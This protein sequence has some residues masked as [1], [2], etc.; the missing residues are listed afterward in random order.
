MSEY[1][2]PAAFS[3]GN[4]NCT[5]IPL[6]PFYREFFSPGGRGCLK[7]KVAFSPNSWGSLV[8]APCNELSLNRRVPPVPPCLAAGESLESGHGRRRHRDLVGQIDH[9]AGP[10]LSVRWRRLERLPWCLHFCPSV[11]RGVSPRR[12]GTV[13]ERCCPRRRGRAAD[14]APAATVHRDRRSVNVGREAGQG[15]WQA[16]CQPYSRS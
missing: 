2:S 11:Q 7:S 5:S 1:E 6:T 10:G 8:E 16:R 4:G 13:V 9:A 15:P 12:P 14:L 3:V